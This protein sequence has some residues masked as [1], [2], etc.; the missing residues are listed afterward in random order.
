M[1][2]YIYIYIYT[3]IYIYVYVKVLHY[4]HVRRT[5]VCINVHSVVLSM[6]SAVT[7]VMNCTHPNKE[8]LYLGE[9]TRKIKI[10]MSGCGGCMVT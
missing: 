10:K 2:M 3:Y 9:M 1:Y 5:V 7:V 8:C 6:Y 4:K